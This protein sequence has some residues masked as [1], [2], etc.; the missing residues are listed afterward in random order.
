[1]IDAILNLFQR[2]GSIMVVLAAV[3]LALG[4]LLIERLWAVETEIQALETKRAAS[5]APRHD[6]AAL[7]GLRRLALIRAC[8]I[9]APLL[10][11]LGTVNG[12][13]ATFQSILAGGYLVEMSNGISQALLSTQ[14]GLVI[15]VPGLLAERWLMKRM[16]K[17]NCL[18]QSAP[19]TDQRTQS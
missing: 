16:D 9:I 14:Y 10:G 12:M 4:F 3:G 15:A 1:M 7:A 17:L 5:S 11:L 13:I 19:P 8:V 6:G 2:G 18:I